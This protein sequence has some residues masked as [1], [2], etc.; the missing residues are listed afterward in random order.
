MKEI[1]FFASASDIV[2]VLR[3]LQT[4]LPIKYVQLGT[5]D[6]PER[7]IYFDIADIPNAGIATNE[8]ATQSI[9]YL[10]A[11]RDLSIPNSSYSTKKGEK[12]WTLFSGDVVGAAAIG[13][14]GL[15]KNKVLLPGSMWTSDKDE[16]SLQFIKWFQS[17]LKKEGYEKVRHWW[18]GKEA[19]SM[20]KSGIRLA[21]VAEQSP[22]EF[23]LRLP[24]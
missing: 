19:M 9:G 18:V 15:W 7:P 20:L 11:R 14:G 2:P 1:P 23:D 3:R 10:M 24:T 16:T 13:M 21:T 5:L 17:A 12:K 6:Q 22:P 4:H 8:T